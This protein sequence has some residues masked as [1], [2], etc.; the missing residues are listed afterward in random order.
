MS[1]SLYGITVYTIEGES[2]AATRDRY[3]ARPET[4]GRREYG[5]S[6]GGRG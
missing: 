2:N 3:L 4:M 1:A 6:Y 5:G